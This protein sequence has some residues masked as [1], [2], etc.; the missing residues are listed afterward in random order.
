LNDPRASAPGD[1]AMALKI[2]QSLVNAPQVHVS[3][4]KNPAMRGGPFISYDAA[5]VVRSRHSRASL[6]QLSAAKEQTA[7]TLSKSSYLKTSTQ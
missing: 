5:K 3:A 1:F 6:Q 2:M 7:Q 4:L